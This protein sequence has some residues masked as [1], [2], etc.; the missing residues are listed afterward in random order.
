MTLPNFK[1]E[2]KNNQNEIK[3]AKK[4]QTKKKDRR[5]KFTLHPV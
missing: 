2:Q 3:T 5:H 1:G 4:L